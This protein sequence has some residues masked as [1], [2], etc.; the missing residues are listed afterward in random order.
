MDF[1]AAPTHKDVSTNALR[2]YYIIA[3]VATT[4]GIV[5]VG[6]LN[7]FTP[8]QF[9]R[10]EI[11]GLVGSGPGLPT[12]PWMIRFMLPKMVTVLLTT[13]IAVIGAL[14]LLLRP[15]ATALN[16][17][18][19][20]DF[21]P[22]ITLAKAKRSL[23]NLPVVFIPVNILI[24]F[25]IPIFT[26]LFA[27]L[28]A[29]FDFRTSLIFGCRAS[30]VGLIASAIASHHMEAYSRKHLFPYFFADGRLTDIKGVIQISISRRIRFNNRLGALVPL[31]ILIV[32]MF[33]LQWELDTVVITARQYGRGIITF[34]LIIFIYA[35]FATGTLNRVVSGNITRP[36]EDMVHTLNEVRH[37]NFDSKVS[38][39]SNDE[40]GYTG[41][42]INE[43]TQGLKE[44]EQIR[45]SLGLAREVQQ[46]LLPAK[47][48]SIDGLDIAGTSIYCEETGGDYYDF[49]KGANADGDSLRVV[50]GDVSGH[51]I[52][53]ALLM[54][55]ARAL[56]RLRATLPGDLTEIINDA[57]RQLTRDVA[58]SGNFMTLLLMAIEPKK[59]Q[60]HWIRAGHDPALLYDPENDTFTDLK[61][62][63]VALGLDE[64]F[65]YRQ[66]S[67]A[68]LRPGQ[69]VILYSDG[70]WEARNVRGEAFGKDALKSVIRS[71]ASYS[72]QR[73]TEVVIDQL[74]AFLRRKPPEDDVT[75]VVVKIK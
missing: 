72:A 42:T 44:R 68:P 18:K 3:V 13:Y 38:V 20:H 39:V 35:F 40:I 8:L 24:W 21:V 6:T 64:N 33:T 16:H 37:G 26:A 50:I 29:N 30:M 43:M 23:L 56:L 12:L 73:I 75:L 51:G 45:Q 11:L 27:S 71:N 31:V 69:I 66:E 46:R 5:A 62:P 74:Y 22:P 32:T 4:I 28:V 15:V 7:L 61:G 2:G 49:F 41:E 59:K 52:S 65:D 55:T 25:A 63:G 54:A 58:A 70:V 57:N 34:A 1:T 9:I 19:M 14:Y 36:L 60:L 47:N 17:A 53:S 48:P 67:Y 10:N